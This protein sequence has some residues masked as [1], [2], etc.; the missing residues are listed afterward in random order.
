MIHICIKAIDL[1]LVVDLDE[2]GVLVQGMLLPIILLI[3]QNQII[4]VFD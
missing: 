3:L 1:P 4:V 2:V